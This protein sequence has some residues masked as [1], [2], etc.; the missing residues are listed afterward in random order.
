[1]IIKTNGVKVGLIGLHGKFAF[2]DTIS[3]EMIQGVEA[4]DEE[5]YLKQY[6]KELEG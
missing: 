5:V 4:R 1:M 3:E 6:L 2:Y